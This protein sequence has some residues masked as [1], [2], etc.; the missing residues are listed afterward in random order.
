MAADSSS[1]ANYLSTSPFA[2][3]T[4]L[5]E[6]VVMI[7]SKSCVALTLLASAGL[8]DSAA[9]QNYIVNGVVTDPA[10]F[11]GQ[12]P[13]VYPTPLGTGTGGWEASYGKAAAMVAKM[14]LD[15][16]A[17]CLI[18]TGNVPMLICCR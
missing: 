1:L 14:T 11:Y 5:T 6:W 10:Y 13:A 9:A 7:Y 3:I 16:K 4:S 12:S 18:V 8:L 15:E 2:I 17:R